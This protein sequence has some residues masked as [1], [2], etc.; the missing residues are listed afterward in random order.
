MGSRVACADDDDGFDHSNDD[1]DDNGDNDDND[2]NDYNHNNDED[3]DLGSVPGQVLWVSECLPPPSH[4]DRP[5]CQEVPWGHS[6]HRG[7][8]P[9]KANLKIFKI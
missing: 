2:D 4:L 3:E 8:G 5:Q 7:L 6:Q 1:N 9:N